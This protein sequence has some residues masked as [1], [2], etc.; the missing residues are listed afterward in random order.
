MRLPAKQAKALSFCI[1]RCIDG[2]TAILIEDALELANEWVLD[3][4]EKAI[5][6]YMVY[7]KDHLIAQLEG[8]EEPRRLLNSYGSSR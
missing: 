7:R 2:P 5:W 3:D 6:E 8:A 4:R 1:V